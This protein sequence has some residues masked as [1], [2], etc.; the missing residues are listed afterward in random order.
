MVSIYD[1]GAGRPYR[2]QHPP[3]SP[4]TLRVTPEA[5]PT[6]G[7]WTKGNIPKD[8]IPSSPKDP[9]PSV[10]PKP[11]TSPTRMDTLI[12]LHVDIGVQAIRLKAL[13]SELDKQMTE[14]WLHDLDKAKGQLGLLSSSVPEMLATL[15]KLSTNGG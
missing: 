2:D 3:H 12:A 14:M 4:K 1:A 15:G 13:R 9:A 10:P 11:A 8:T 5:P 6:L 7:V